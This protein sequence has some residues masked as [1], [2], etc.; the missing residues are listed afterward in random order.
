ML[1]Y[2]YSKYFV[3]KKKIMIKVHFWFRENTHLHL[4]PRSCGERLGGTLLEA[5]VWL[6]EEEEG[7]SSGQGLSPHPLGTEGIQQGFANW[8]LFL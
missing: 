4:G 5:R 3:G 8:F 7:G 1:L 6:E 2:V